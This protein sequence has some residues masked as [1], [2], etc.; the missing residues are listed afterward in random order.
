MAQNSDLH[1]VLDRVAATALDL[2]PAEAAVVLLKHESRQM[3]QVSATAG[4][5]LAQ[6][7]DLIPLDHGVPGQIARSGQPRVCR[8]LVGEQGAFAPFDEERGIRDA[9][10]VPLSAAGKTYGVLGVLNRAR[11]S[12]DSA[13]VEA[14]QKVA[15][16]AAA[17]EAMRSVGPLRQRL[18]DGSLI[19]EVGRAVTGTL[20]LDEVLPVVVRAAEML[21]S[22][23]CAAVALLSDDSRTLELAATSGSLLTKQGD[24]FPVQG[25]LTGWVVQ[26]GEAVVSSGIGQDERCDLAESKLG[27][28]VIIP[29]ESGT[30]VHG[31][32]LAA[33]SVGA[34]VPSDGDEDALRKLAAYAAIAIENARL[35]REQTELSQKL[36]A[37]TDELERAYA[38]LSDSQQ[39]L[40]V[41]EKMAALGRV[42]A[43]LAHEI[44]SPLGGIL[45]CLQMA[46]TYVGEYRSSIND[47]DVKPQDHEAIA[48]DLT[49][50]LDLAE[51][52]TRKVAQF[53]RTIKGQTRT[54]ED[55]VRTELEAADEID[56]VLAVLQHE[57][58]S[59]N[60]TL[61]TDVARGVPLLGDPG[62]FSLVVQNLLKNAIDAY[63]GAEGQVRIS[64][65][66]AGPDK[67]ILEVQDYGCGI[68][69]EI[70]GRIFDYLFTTKDIGEGTGLGLSTVHS[71][72]TSH[73]LGEVDFESAE[74]A[75]TKFVVTFP[76]SNVKD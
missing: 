45:N 39:R 21:M 68:P 26:R 7:G 53:V 69:E 60:V 66:A 58:R 71:I 8:S 5:P 25:S 33:R 6:D 56:G 32:L 62:K 30:R 23:K 31:A 20:G 12:D 59:R 41:S 50:A 2:V 57:I 55:D 28:G 64:W 63:E 48:T 51:Q 35:Y 9:L 19:A 47:P 72:V 34:P 3:L 52:S 40:L 73:F 70:R 37:K 44:N 16:Q 11:G 46:Q 67:A 54:G 36:R 75:G 13:C 29:I 15:N 1:G 17:I 18:S 4:K 42:T 38:D 27:A 76:I 65:S 22:A 10:L 61:K 74:G 24:T 43:G 14:L 49:E